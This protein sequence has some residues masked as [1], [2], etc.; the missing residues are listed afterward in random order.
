MIEHKGTFTVEPGIIHVSDWMNTPEGNKVSQL[1]LNGKV[2]VNKEATGCGFTSWCLWN[3]YNTILISPRIRLIHNKIEQS[4]PPGSYYYFDRD[5]INKKK[6]KSYAQLENEFLV[7]SQE[8]NTKGLPFKILVTYDSFEKLADMMESTFKLDLGK[9]SIA[10]DESHSL[11]KDVKLKEN[12]IE[13]VLPRFLSR[14]FRYP[15]LLFISA[16]PIVDYIKAVP[17]FVSS[18]VSY[19]E[20]KWSNIDVITSRPRSTRSSMSAF[21]EIYDHWTKTQD[22]S[23]RNV[24][25]EYYSGSN[26]YYSY[27]AVIFLNN[28]KDICTILGKYVKKLGLINPSDVTVI[29]QDLPGHKIKLHKVHKSID[30]CGAIP[31]FGQPHTTW[32][33]VTRTAFEGVDFY[34]PSASTYVI[35]NYNVSSLCLDIASDI[36]QIAGRQRRLD[37]PFRCVLNIFF[38]KNEGYSDEDYQ[39]MQAEKEDKSQKQIDLWNTTRED[40]KETVTEAIQAFIEKDP[41]ANYIRI[42]DG[43]PQYTELL[44]I[45][46]DYSRDI[47]LNHKQWYIIQD[48]S[49]LTYYSEP[50]KQLLQLLRQPVETRL[51]LK[52][53]YQYLSLAPTEDDVLE[54]YSMLFREG[55][56]KLS[57]YFHK[58]PLDRILANGFNITRLDYEIGHNNSQDVIRLGLLEKMVPGM[59]YSSKDIKLMV[60]EVYDQ[61]GVKAKAKSTDIQI[62]VPE[63][64]IKKVHGSYYYVLP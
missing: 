37:N 34:S 5:S 54:V 45:A 57:S 4:D 10:I 3:P 51:K 52:Y 8:R 24:F 7:Y 32:T 41:N 36:P 38:T 2:I 19:Y 18:D 22:P 55:Y 64:Q 49:Y 27:E 25:D 42:V 21:D 58:L 23:G 43:K 1:F 39:K 60:Q 56:Q 20:L 17:E 15:N 28:I 13:P 6:Q 40:L 53:I 59:K 61:N 46:E 9:F 31:K 48:A 47:F 44:R 30:I 50:V 29:C 11:I 62:Y 33:F 26:V 14:L 63:C 16:T 12:S 35:T